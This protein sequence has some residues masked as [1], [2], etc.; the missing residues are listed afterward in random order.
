MKLVLDNNAL[1]SIM[2]PKSISTYLFSSIKA[3]FLAPEFIKSELEKH[4]PEC[5]DKS[6]LSE[7]EFEMRQME[8][9]ELIEFFKLSKYEEFFEESKNVLPDPNDADFLALALLTNSSIWS[10]DPHLKQQS[11]VP[12]FTTA[13]LVKMFFKREI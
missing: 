10:N 1:F 5:I 2:N 9:E 11:L 4:K 6:R 8:I 13:E 7:Q 3:E 12:V